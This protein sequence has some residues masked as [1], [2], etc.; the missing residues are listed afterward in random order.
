[1]GRLNEVALLFTR[2]D[3]AGPDLKCGI[4]LD[5]FQ[6]RPD[7]RSDAYTAYGGLS[8]RLGLQEPPRDSAG[9]H[10]DGKI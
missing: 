6:R 8:L 5:V 2:C 3:P 1:M 9:S 4:R 10:T 7:R